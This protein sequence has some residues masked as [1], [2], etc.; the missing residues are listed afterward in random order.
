MYDDGKASTPHSRYMR[1]RV[2]AR[3]KRFTYKSGGT[4]RRCVKNRFLRT[5]AGRKDTTGHRFLGKVEEE[6]L[7]RADEA[8]K[9]AKQSKDAL[10]AIETDLD[11]VYDMVDYIAD[12]VDKMEKKDKEADGRSE[13]LSTILSNMKAIYEDS[14]EEGKEIDLACS[15][16]KQSGDMDD[17]DATKLLKAVEKSVKG[18]EEGVLT[19][20]ALQTV[21][22]DME[23]TVVAAKMEESFKQKD[24]ELKEMVK[25]E[26]EIIKEELDALK[27]KENILKGRLK[28]AKSLSDAKAIIDQ[29]AELQKLM[30]EQET[31]AAK[32]EAEYDGFIEDVKGKEEYVQTMMNLEFG[33]EYAE[34]YDG[35]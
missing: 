3:R 1:H 35:V 4:C 27:E 34:T 30:L 13:A 8:C 18:M 2:L 23:K 26:K 24:E 31:M 32:L 33:M 21:V 14:K 16:A 12:T 7:S 17:K 11:D 19:T 6:S 22:K 9:L 10:K 28:E 15:L 20:K 25:S 29:E 5:K